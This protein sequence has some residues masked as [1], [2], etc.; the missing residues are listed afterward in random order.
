MQKI[1]DYIYFNRKEVCIVIIFLILF[2]S[3][4][5]MSKSDENLEE[6]KYEV[7]EKEKVNDINEKIMID[8]KGEVNNPGTYE[9]DNNKRVIDAI[10]EAGGLKTTAFTDDINLSEKLSDEMVIYIPQKEENKKSDNSTSNKN[11]KIVNDGKISIN[12]ASVSDFT[13][14]NGIGESKAK[15]IVEYR[16]QF[17]KFKSIEEIKNVSGIGNSTFEK[18]KDYIKV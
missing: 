4:I 1:K 6:V 8:V 7:I 15:K 5:V 14:I 11:I 17:G 13:K 12:T 10:N 2:I 16:T 3:Y 18:I 9:M